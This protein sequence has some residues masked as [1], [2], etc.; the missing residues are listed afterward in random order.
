[1]SISEKYATLMDGINEATKTTKDILDLHAQWLCLFR[2]GA[3]GD[4]KAYDEAARSRQYFEA[5]EWVPKEIVLQLALQLKDKDMLLEALR[6][7]LNEE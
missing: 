2:K 6:T 3:M 5:K 4:P 7:K 1:M